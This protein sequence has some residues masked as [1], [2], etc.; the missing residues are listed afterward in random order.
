MERAKEGTVLILALQGDLYPVYDLMEAK[1]RCRWDNPSSSSSSTS[2][3]P[4]HVAGTVRAPWTEED[5]RSLVAHA[6]DA[7]NGVVLMGVK[8]G[9]EG[10]RKRRRARRKKDKCK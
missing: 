4:Q 10:G 3:G 8:R 1:Q 2:S 7:L 6:A 9:R 5:E